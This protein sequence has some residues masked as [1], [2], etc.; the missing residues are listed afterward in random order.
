MRF[1]SVLLEMCCIDS[2]WN[3]VTP[4][5]CYMG[6]G[7]KW[8]TIGNRVPFG[9]EATEQWNRF[10]LVILILWRECVTWGVCDDGDWRFYPVTMFCS[11][12]LSQGTTVSTCHHIVRKIIDLENRSIIQIR[13]CSHK[14]LHNYIRSFH[15]RYSSK[16]QYLM[17]KD[18][19]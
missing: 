12:L 3:C 7:Q 13:S 14:A 19:M 10:L 2:Q 15:I 1:V 11:F 8:Y 18:L 4:I 6:T 9:T 16:D 17:W 5:V